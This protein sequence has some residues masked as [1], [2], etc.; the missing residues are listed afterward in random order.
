M[1]N[2]P[3]R[4]RKLLKFAAMLFS[5]V[6]ILHIVA[7]NTIFLNIRREKLGKGAK[8]LHISDLHE[9][10][11]G[12]NNSRLIRA[13]EKEKPDLIFITGDLVSRSETDFTKAESLLN[14]LC[15]IAP[16]Y[17]VCGNH[18]QSL[19][20][21]VKKDFLEMVGRTKA[22]L[23]I[24]RSCTVNVNGRELNICG[25]QQKY[26]TYKKNDSYRDLED[27]TLPQMEK[28]LGECPEGEG[29]LL[30]AHNPK[31]GKVYSEWGADY[32]FSGHIHGGSVRLFGVG[33]LSPERKFFPRYSKGV[34]EIGGMKLLVSAGLGKL[35]A[36]DTP[37]LVVYEI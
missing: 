32:T 9:R 20:G 30:L 3:T 15:E 16:V 37:E 4:S 33:I 14:R 13:A 11:F 35:R 10:N 5:A 28:L 21:S 34:Y 29:T 26:N 7:E 6:V 18:E 12:K 36:F 19:P 25:V 22:E 27:F 1:N 8:I 24:N 23:L 31:W 17:M 2:K